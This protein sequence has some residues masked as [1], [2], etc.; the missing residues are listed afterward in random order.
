MLEHKGT[1]KT[2]IT[3]DKARDAWWAWV[4]EWRLALDGQTLV[5]V[6]A[7]DTSVI[8]SEWNRDPVP[9]NE[10]I[11]RLVGEQGR[12]PMGQ[13]DWFQLQEVFADGHRVRWMLIVG[14]AQHPGLHCF[15]TV[16]SDA[17][18]ELL[19]DV[20]I[21]YCENHLHEQH[22]AD[23]DAGLQACLSRAGAAVATMPSDQIL[24]LWEVDDELFNWIMG[25]GP[26][27]R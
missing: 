3:L 14:L 9:I 21:V 27:P 7:S 13:F 23:F 6:T 16:L 5:A 20:E 1:P 2:E 17:G 24:D 18:R 15:L 19:A 22:D 12:L 25:D 10:V 11:T 26:D 4:R 8:L